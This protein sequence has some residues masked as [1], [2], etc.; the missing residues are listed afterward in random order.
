M[1]SPCAPLREMDSLDLAVCLTDGKTEAGG[2]TPLGLGPARLGA[3]ALGQAWQPGVWVPLHCGTRKRKGTSGHLTPPSRGSQRNR[4]RCC[5]PG[6][7][8]WGLRANSGA[9]SAG[10]GH[11]PL[12]RRSRTRS[13]H[14]PSQA[15]DRNHTEPSS[16]GHRLQRTC[17]LPSGSFPGP[18]LHLTGRPLPS[19]SP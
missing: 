11:R 4:L 1:L 12:S 14:V 19:P 3:L 2:A 10:G 9:R 13:C 15:T 18:S 16:P 5:F 8:S 17:G 6:P 7:L